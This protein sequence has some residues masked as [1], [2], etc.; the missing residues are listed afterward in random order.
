MPSFFI[1]FP[2]LVHFDGE[3]SLSIPKAM[4]RIFPKKINVIFYD[5]NEKS[6]FTEFYLVLLYLVVFF[7]GLVHF[8]GETSL[9]ISKAME[10]TFEKCQRYFS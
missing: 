8:D 10:P 2:G 6:V 7:S 4:E 9:S 5:A 3:T 1:F